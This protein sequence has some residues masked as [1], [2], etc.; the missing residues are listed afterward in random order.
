MKDMFSV[1]ILYLL[2]S[3]KEGYKI[4]NETTILVQRIMDVYIV[5][6]AHPQDAIS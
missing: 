6:K 2:W 5:L 3:F 1:M 4:F